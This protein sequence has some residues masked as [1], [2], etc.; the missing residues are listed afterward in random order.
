MEEKIIDFEYIEH[1]FKRKYQ[2][3]AFLIIGLIAGLE[4]TYIRSE[5]N[6]IFYLILGILAFTNY[7]P[8]YFVLKKIKCPYCEKNYFTPK[9]YGH[10][11]LKKLIK[12]DPSCINCK[13]KAKIISEY[14]DIY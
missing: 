14:F 2:I 7:V 13:Q 6:T 9:M 11:M 12:S 8:N 5:Y 3:I 10:E 1:K 4:V